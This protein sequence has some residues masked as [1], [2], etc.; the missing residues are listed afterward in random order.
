M[1]KVLASLCARNPRRILLLDS[2]PLLVTNE[3]RALVKLAGQIVLVVRAG[4]TPRQAVQA[5]IDLFDLRQAGGVV[6]NQ[7]PGASTG[8]YYGYGSYGTDGSQT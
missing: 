8:E 6:L 2:P 3:G 5:A 4:Q 7:V 1:A